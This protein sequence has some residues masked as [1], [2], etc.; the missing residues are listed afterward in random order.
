[1]RLTHD[2]AQEVFDQFPNGGIVPDQFQNFDSYAPFGAQPAFTGPPTPPNQHPVAGVQ[3]GINGSAHAQQARSS[4]GADLSGL[5]GI[6]KAE[7]DEQ[8]RRQGSNS[9]EDELTPAQSRRKAQNRAAYVV[10][11]PVAH[12]PHTRA[13]FV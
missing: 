11:I 13:T 12:P 1:V 3:P 10:A 9:E 7:S 2:Y 4:V 5:A 6:S 8:A